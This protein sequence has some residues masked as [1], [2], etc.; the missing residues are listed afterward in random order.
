MMTLLKAKVRNVRAVEDTG[1]FEPGRRI[2]FFSGNGIAASQVLSALGTINPLYTI[3]EVRPFADHPKVW[4]QGEHRRMV[5]P[6]K[7]TAAFMIFAADVALVRLL[8]RIEDDLIETDRI[9]FG[10][11][12]DY[13]SW[14]SFVEISESARWSDI[15]SDMGELIEKGAGCG[16]ELDG[17][18]RQLPARTR[19]KGGLA[20][21]LENWLASLPGSIRQEHQ[22]LFDRCRHELG[23]DQRFMLARRIAGEYLPPTL[24][25]T[26]EEKPLVRV[27]YAELGKDRGQEGVL[28]LLLRKALLRYGLLGG[29]G[30]TLEQF[31]DALATAAGSLAAFY[32]G[33][34]PVVTAD[35]HGISFAP[36][37]GSAGE[38]GQA[39]VQ[40]CL[41]TLLL[42]GKMPVLLLDRIH[43]GLTGDRGQQLLRLVSELSGGTQIICSLGDDDLSCCRDIPGRQFHLDPHGKVTALGSS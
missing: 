22:Q 3:E 26:A 37:S 9:E 34:C 30:E 18:I 31:R 33:E 16:V 21:Q 1:W 15:D 39:I 43:D 40:T 35:E 17:E 20:D 19:L 23:R 25:L 32:P 42:W 14:T 38:R 10:R 41:L 7:K 13:S 11:R 27:E 2:S 8:E 29:G 6:A 28:G 24:G 36:L 12:L 5:I 4:R